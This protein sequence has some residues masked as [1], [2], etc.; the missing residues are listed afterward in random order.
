MGGSFVQIITLPECLQGQLPINSLRRWFR[1]GQQRTEFLDT[2][3][4]VAE[5]SFHRRVTRNEEWTRQKL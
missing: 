1:F 4:V 2:P 5:S 3:N